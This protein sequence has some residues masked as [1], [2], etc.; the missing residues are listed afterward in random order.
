[1]DQ[2]F[3]LFEFNVYDERVK[4][5][6]QEHGSNKKDNNEFVI[7]Y[8]IDP[9]SNECLFINNKNNGLPFEKINIDNIYF[10]GSNIEIKQLKEINTLYLTSDNIIETYYKEDIETYI[11]KNMNKHKLIGNIILEELVKKVFHPE[12]LLRLSKKSNIDLDMYIE[13]Y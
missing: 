8:C 4:S 1:M 3:R 6:D 2:S 11:D 9:I 5:D 13:L 10:M 12:R 7:F